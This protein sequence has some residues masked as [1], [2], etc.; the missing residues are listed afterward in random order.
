[1]RDELNKAIIEEAL[2][3]PIGRFT[4]RDGS[5]NRTKIQQLDPGFRQDALNYIFIQRSVEVHGNFYGYER[6]EFKS[7]KQLVEIWCPDHG[8]YFWQ[9]AGSHMKGSSCPTCSRKLVERIT[10]YG[11]VSVPARFHLYR[12]EENDIVFYNYREE[13]KLEIGNDQSTI[14]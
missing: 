3:F 10:P 6:S 1:M 9:N 12:I 14:E 2:T 11:T 4:K 7:Q 13:Y 8:E 5:I